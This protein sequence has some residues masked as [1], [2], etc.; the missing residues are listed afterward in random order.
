MIIDGKALAKQKRA[1][2]TQIVQELKA[3]GVTPG[4]AVVLVGEDPASEIYVRNKHKACEE[5]G[6]YSRVIK[7]P[8]DTKEE[9]LLKLID[10]LN[11]DNALDG[12]LVQLPLPKQ[13]NPDKVIERI[14][15]NKD[16]DGFHPVN[17]GKL[18]TGQTGFVSCT[19]L[20][21]LELIKSTGIDISGKEAV[22]IG[23]SNIV[24][25]PVAHLLLQE[26]AT[27]TI[28]HSKTKNLKEVCQRADILVAAVGKP[29]LITA[30]YV[31]EGAV[32]IDV[33]INRLSDGKLVGD[34]A[35]ETV[36]EKASYITPVPGGVGP[37]TI[38][39]LLSNTLLSAKNR[40]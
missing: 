14:L 33:G 13:I 17:A 23:R 38:T 24:G 7:L 40:V 3:M 34:V 30:D 28:C 16:V 37:M 8:E 36:K 39:M 22:V 21:I 25:K 32:V 18:L 12:I 1:E 31:K 10:E 2:M 9:D 6:I 11:Q 19:P 20:G 35:F 5:V 29:Q 15:P 4:L 27:V 26:N